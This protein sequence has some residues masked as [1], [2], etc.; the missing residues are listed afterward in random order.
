VNAISRNNKNIYEAAWNKVEKRDS[1]PGFIYTHLLMPHSPYYYNHNGDPYPF[2][3][4]LEGHQTNKTNYLEYLQ[5]TNKKLIALID[6]IQKISI[7]PPI[8]I[9]MSDHGF[10]RISNDTDKKYHFL[11]LTSI[12]LPEKYYT[13]F[14]D[15]MS[16]VNLF[17]TL[18]NIR[19]GQNLPMLQDSTIYLERE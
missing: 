9:V 3:Q 8:I 16:N 12:Y 11:N 2:E 10:R 13:P 19:F 6:R 5:Y 17:R 4:L 1:K 15:G 7:K 18:L 14:K